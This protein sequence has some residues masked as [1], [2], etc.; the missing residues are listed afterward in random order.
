MASLTI[1]IGAF[2]PAIAIGKLA[3]KAMESIGRN[4]EAAPKIQTAMILAIAFAEAIAIY[5][6]VVALIIKFV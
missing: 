4:P 5:A 2:S 1:A 6:L 3:S